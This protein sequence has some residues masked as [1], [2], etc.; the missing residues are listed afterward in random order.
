MP[1]DGRIEYGTTDSDVV[2]F[3]EPFP[4]KPQV[5]V[6]GA[7]ITYVTKEGFVLEPVPE[8]PVL[9]VAISRRDYP[10]TWWLRRNEPEY[11]IIH[12]RKNDGLRQPGTTED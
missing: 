12:E 6:T 5:M 4:E 11:R 9:W 7:Y 10:C 3:S 2:I 1:D 8:E